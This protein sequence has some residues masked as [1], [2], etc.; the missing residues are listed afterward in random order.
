M[1]Y[2][3]IQNVNGNNSVEAEGLEKQGAIVR[4]CQIC[5]NLWNSADVYNA[6]VGIY[7]DKLNLLD[8]EYGLY[9]QHIEHPTPEPEQPQGE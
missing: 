5:A 3:V 4:F 6:E 1:K 7:D 9:K 8:C 2:S